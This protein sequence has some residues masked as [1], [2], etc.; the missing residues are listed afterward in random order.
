MTQP[1]DRVDT[2]E[3]LR[4]RPDDPPNI[5]ALRFAVIG[6]GGVLAIGLLAVFGRIVYLTTRPPTAI[7]VTPAGAVAPIGTVSAA[8]ANDIALALPAGAKVRSQSLAGNR[9]SVHYEAPAGDGIIILDLETG[10]PVSQVRLQ[11][12][13]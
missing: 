8:I 13:R 2:F 10:R 11:S 7:A 5:K 1:Q 12:G 6:M 9:L 4:A 3:L